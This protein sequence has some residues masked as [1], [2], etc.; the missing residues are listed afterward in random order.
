MLQ[1][2][3]KFDIRNVYS[4]DWPVQDALKLKLKYTSDAEK[5]KST[6]KIEANFKK[7]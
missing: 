2:V 7:I 6:R 1:M 5:K 4:K 3:Q